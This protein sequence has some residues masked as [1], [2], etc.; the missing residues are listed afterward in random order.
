LRLS[1]FGITLYA[2]H[3]HLRPLGENAIVGQR[4]YQVD[5]TMLYAKEISKATLEVNGKTFHLPVYMGTEGEIALD[6]R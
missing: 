6:S 1:H 4:L 5:F 2:L 3:W